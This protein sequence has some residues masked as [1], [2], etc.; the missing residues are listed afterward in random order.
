MPTR[1]REWQFRRR[2]ELGAQFF[3][4]GPILDPD[5]MERHVGRLNLQP[6]DPPVYVMIIPPFSASWVEQMEAIGSVPVGEELKERLSD[7]DP[8]VGR[9]LGW[10][11][12]GELER[13]AQDAGAAG[14]I[15]MG[16]KYDSVV[17]EAADRWLNR[18]E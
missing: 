1:F 14:V 16:L 3:V 15:L 10:E 17:G 8:E 5:V 11:L 13:R 18:G 6:E 2:V 4:T 9:K 7:L 12:T